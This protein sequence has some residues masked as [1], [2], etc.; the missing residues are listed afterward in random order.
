MRYDFKKKITNKFIQKFENF[1]ETRRI[2]VIEPIIEEKTISQNH[3]G[4][5]TKLLV[6]FITKTDLE[7]AKMS[8]WWTIVT[9]SSTSFFSLS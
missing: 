3:F 8:L 9:K 1:L 5:S 4:C 2:E 6:H 7:F